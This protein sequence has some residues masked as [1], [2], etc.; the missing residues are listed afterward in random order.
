M[1]RSYHRGDR[2]IRVRG[3][4]RHPADL[5]RLA[6]ALILIVQAEAEAEAQRAARDQRVR[7]PDPENDEKKRTD[8]YPDGD[9]A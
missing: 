8:G 3:L 5:R 9:A 4:R 1:S 6:K 7:N 2:R